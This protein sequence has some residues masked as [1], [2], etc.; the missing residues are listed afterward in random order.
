MN[1]ILSGITT[2]EYVRIDILSKKKKN[3]KFR[4]RNENVDDTTG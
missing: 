3:D 1:K 4:N 2:K